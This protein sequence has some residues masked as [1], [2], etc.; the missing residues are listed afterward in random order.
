MARKNISLSLDICI[1]DFIAFAGRPDEN[2]TGARG[3]SDR[4][5]QKKERPVT[6]WLFLG[7]QE[8]ARAFEE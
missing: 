7:G 2:T 6:S 4:G 5:A 8:V 3:S 1:S